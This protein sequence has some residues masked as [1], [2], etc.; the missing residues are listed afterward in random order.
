[1][2]SDDDIPIIPDLDDLPDETNFDELHGT[3]AIA[4]NRVATYKELNT[5]LLK[6]TAFASSENID[7]SKLMKCLQD[8]AVLMDSDTPLTTDQLFNEV[9][10]YVHSF[11]NKTPEDSPKYVN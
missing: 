11:Q 9:A 3:Q 1:M 6:Y 2:L 4:V 8:E 7:L 5:E 10:T